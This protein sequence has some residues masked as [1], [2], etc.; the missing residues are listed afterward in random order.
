M[1][2]GYD[3]CRFEGYSL[4]MLRGSCPQGLLEICAGPRAHEIRSGWERVSSSS[5]AEVYRFEYE[6]RPYYYKKY[7]ERKG[8][9]TVK[10][11]VLGSRARRAWRGGCLLAASGL[12]APQMVVA[13]WRGADCFAVTRAVVNARVLGEYVQTL[14]ASLGPEARRKRWLV[15]EEL[16]RVVGRMHARRIAHGDLRWGNILVIEEQEGGIRF[17][18]LDN[19]RTRCYPWLPDRK[20]LKNLV[21]LNMVHDRVL[22][23][24]ERMRFW[25][26]YR[27]ENSAL[28]GEHKQWVRRVL[29]RTAWRWARRAQK[30]REP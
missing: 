28:R 18:F 7:L 15:A 29:A 27:A 10:A 23:R 17:V 4:K 25:Q 2:P 3:D 21:Q 16:G 12:G 13:G 20:V 14:S 9:E 26:A 8:L 30:N 11:W 5:F 22:S 1:T 24:T 19:E 6:G